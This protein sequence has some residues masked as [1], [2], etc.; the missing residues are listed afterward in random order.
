MIMLQNGNSELVINP[1]GGRVESLKLDGHHTLI[2]VTRGDGKKGSTHPC[3]PIFGPETTT[4]FGLSQHGPVRTTVMEV[5]HQTQDSVTLTTEIKQGSYPRNV[6]IEQLFE[7]GPQ[8]LLITTT[9]INNGSQAV[10]VNFGEHFY[11]STPHGWD[12]IK[13]NGITVADKVKSNGTESLNKVNTIEI[14]GLPPICLEQTGMNTAVIWAY[15]KTDGTFDTEYACIEPAEGDPMAD[16]FGT[17]ESL[18]APN[19]RRVTTLHI[20]I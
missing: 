1:D 19:T 7:L 3:S 10:P 9:H 2:S 16:F 4:A 11:W 5:V 17:K 20:S 15:K 18:I 14:E 13:L 12:D 6:F 8:S